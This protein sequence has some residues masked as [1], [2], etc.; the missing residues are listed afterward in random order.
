[1]ASNARMTAYLRASARV[2]ICFAICQVFAETL[3][4]ALS[5][6]RYLTMPIV[7]D[8]QMYDF[9]VKLWLW[10]PGGEA[11]LRS[12]VPDSFTG[13]G[14]GPKLGLAGGLALPNLVVVMLLAI[15][16][17]WVR[18]GFRR[19]VAERPVLWSLVGFGL[20]VHLIAFVVAVH[21]PKGWTFVAVARNAAHVLV[22]E[23]AF[24][25][26]SVL[27]VAAGI[28]MQLLRVGS[29]ALWIASAATAALIVMVFPLRGVAPV[30]AARLQSRT[31]PLPP[32]ISNVILISID[33]LRSD[34]LGCYGLQ[35][36]TSPAIDSLASQGVRFS[37][38]MSTTSWTL[39]SHLSLLTGRNLLSHGVITEN[40]RLP[41]GI[42]TLAEGLRG[43]GFTT[44]GIISMLYLGRQYGFD[45]GFDEYDD[46]SVPAATWYD[47]LRDE[48]AP[49]VTKL[50]IEWLRRNKNSRF[51]LFL[52]F[53]DVHYDYVPPPPYDAMFDPGYQGTL[54]GVNFY[55][56]KSINQ[57]MPARDLQHI[58]ALYDGEVR[59]V[60]DHIG[61]I[62]R[63]IE[64]LGID[65]HTAIIVTADHGDEFFE[66]GNKGHHKTLYREVL[67]VP[68]VMRIPGMAAGQVIDSPVSLVDVMPTVL[69]LAGAPLPPGMDGVSLAPLIRG[70]PMGTP[71]GVY[72]WLCN[73]RLGRDCEA[74]QH[75]ATGTLIHRFQPMAMEFY[76]PDDPSERRD[77]SR[78]D[79]WPRHEELGLLQQEL[80]EQRA[81]YR[82]DGARQTH[83]AI[84]KATRE[85]LR[86]LGYGD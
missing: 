12:G 73:P 48:P 81:S 22:W 11:W 25:A 68:L 4:I 10:I 1:M 76:G 8:Q 83:V 69:E 14:V 6:R 63:A 18:Y 70:Q 31:A 13:E 77:L 16:V 86:A 56:N 78:S 61:E 55:H 47:A 15:G 43:A 53:W 19:S 26:L 40:D 51:F 41:D 17:A 39:P 24:I 32:A 67:Q 82:R 34:Q 2:A 64:E 23:R 57:R 79:R 59:W 3:V 71:R 37:N 44:G 85:R 74:M 30:E 28:S 58:I 49:V 7:L 72:A 80:T 50:A 29:A 20:A 42:P 62:L 60:D 54:T 21:I 46:K 5:Y 9:C 52:H 36:P 38:V 65:D 84:D 27:A 75:T 35:R 45:R 33:S 66:H